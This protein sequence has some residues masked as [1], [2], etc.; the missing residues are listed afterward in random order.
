MK[1]YLAIKNEIWVVEKLLNMGYEW[2]TKPINDYETWLFISIE[3]ENGYGYLVCGI[4]NC[5]TDKI[6]HIDEVP[7]KKDL[8]EWIKM[9]NNGTKLGLL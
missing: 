9:I 1:K 4:Y 5:N 6:I 7:H 2:Y 3:N 8:D